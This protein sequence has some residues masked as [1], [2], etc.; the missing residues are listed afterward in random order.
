MTPQHEQAVRLAVEQLAAALLDA[1][2]EESRPDPTA[3]ERLYDLRQAGQLLG[4]LS[5]SALYEGPIAH[6]E[7]RTVKAGRRRLVSTSAI[8]DYIASR[9]GQ[10]PVGGGH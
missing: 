9:D 3:P 2:R 8:A 7:L 1:L 4:G 6:G 5:R 10:A